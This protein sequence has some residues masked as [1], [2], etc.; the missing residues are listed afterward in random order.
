LFLAIVKEITRAIKIRS[1]LASAQRL[2][3]SA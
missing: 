2:A 3:C 1:I